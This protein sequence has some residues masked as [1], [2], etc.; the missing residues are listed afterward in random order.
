MHSFN[1]VKRFRFVVY[2]IMFYVHASNNYNNNE[3]SFQ[4]NY[5][6]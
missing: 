1:I 4:N 3:E 6:N 5:Y 2:V